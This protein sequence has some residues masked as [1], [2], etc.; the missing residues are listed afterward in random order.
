MRLCPVN[1][2]SV[3]LVLMNKHT[4]CSGRYNKVEKE[5]GDKIHLEPL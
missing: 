4:I 5:K 3:G 1:V 2:V